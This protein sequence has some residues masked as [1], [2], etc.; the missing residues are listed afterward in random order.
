MIYH[1]IIFNLLKVV[2]IQY[3]TTEKVGLKKKCAVLYKINFPVINS[4]NKIHPEIEYLPDCSQSFNT[5]LRT[6]VYK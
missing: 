5:D 3:V 6:F 4:K 1:I 2:S